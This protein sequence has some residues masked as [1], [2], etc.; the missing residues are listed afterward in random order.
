[1][2]SSVYLCVNPE[3]DQGRDVV[4]VISDAA[5]SEGM[6]ITDVASDADAIISIGGDGTFLYASHLAVE[7]SIP[8]AGINLGR[9]GFLPSYAPDDVQLVIE[10]LQMDAH[11]SSTPVISAISNGVTTT[12]V[13]EVVIERKRVDRAIRL[14]V[15]ICQTGQSPGDVFTTFVCDGIIVA[16]PM[17]STAYA[18]SVGGPVVTQGVNGK[19]LTFAA[20]HHPKIAPIVCDDTQSIFIRPQDESILACDGKC[21]M[22]LE[23]G[24]MVEVVTSTKTLYICEDHPSILQRLTRS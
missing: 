24:T 13:N 20:L 2:I 19:V 7:N 1:M 15:A 16:T 9:F 21:I 11:F 12:V 3:K 5:R 18:S 6:T 10:H 8:V 23:I 17:G 22:E 4:E 14:D